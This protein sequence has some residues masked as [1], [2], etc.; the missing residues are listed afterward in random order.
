MEV[1]TVAGSII[2]VPIGVARK[3][4]ELGILGSGEAPPLKSIIPTISAR[5]NPDIFLLGFGALQFRV[6]L[7]KNFGCNGFLKLCPAN[8]AAGR[9][10]ETN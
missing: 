10:H 7:L 4:G 5:L 6:R 8:R 9:T 2:G 3:D 1:G